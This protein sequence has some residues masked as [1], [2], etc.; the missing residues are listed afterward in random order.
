VT[1]RKTGLTIAITGTRQVESREEILDELFERVL[2]PF[3]QA[4]SPDRGWL[5]GGAAGVDTLALRFL[6]GFDSGRL[7]VAVPV[8]T[9]DQPADAQSAIKRAQAAGRIDR[10]VELGHTDGI[11]QS[12]FT[13]RN[14]WLVE[15]SDLV[16]GFP[17]SA[18]DDGSG[19]WE[20]LNYAAELGKPY[21]AAAL[22]R[23]E[24]R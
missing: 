15:H 11:G 23:P 19:T 1:S 3:A 7:T 10:V 20:T 6:A 21:L 16:I 9:T 17:L 2:T 22:N 13:A 18:T 14:F 8:R 5:L 24:S 12:A 4:L